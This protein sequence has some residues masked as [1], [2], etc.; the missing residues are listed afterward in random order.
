MGLTAVAFVVI[1]IYGLKHPSQGTPALSQAENIVVAVLVA[2]I[3]WMIG[4]IGA[5]LFGFSIVMTGKFKNELVER[6]LVITPEGLSG[7]SALGEGIIKWNGIHKVVSTKKL[8]IIYTNE[9]TASFV[10]KRFFSSPEAA[11]AFEQAIRSK[12]PSV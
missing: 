2:F 6:T 8:L 3:I 10:P 9:T 7:K 4:M 1:L 11:A 5:F 12:M